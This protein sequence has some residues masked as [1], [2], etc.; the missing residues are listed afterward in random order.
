[1]NGKEKVVLTVD[2]DIGVRKLLSDIITYAGYRPL[3]A[4]TSREALEML[5]REQVDLMLLD[6]NLPGIHG[7]QFL[8][9]LRD[10]GDTTPVI[11]ISGFLN[12][13]VV[14]EVMAAGVSAVMTKPVDVNRLV[15]A[16]K[17]ALKEEMHGT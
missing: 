9:F 2:N 16:M 8:K 11:V 7:S 6:I 17:K 15:T 10:R 4:T 5:Q 13:E 14:K 3:E 12:K 1:M